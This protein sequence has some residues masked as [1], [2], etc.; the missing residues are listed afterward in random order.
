MV[1][2]HGKG[3]DK[4]SQKVIEPSKE[5]KVHTEQYI[6]QVWQ[7]RHSGV[8]KRFSLGRLNA[9]QEFGNRMSAISD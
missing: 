3:I 8:N 6:S 9:L 5:A 2:Q 4:A 7:Y 1:N